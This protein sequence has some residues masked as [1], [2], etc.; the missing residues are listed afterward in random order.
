M[1]AEKREKDKFRNHTMM[2]STTNTLRGC[3]KNEYTN[4]TSVI[5]QVHI[6]LTTDTMQMYYS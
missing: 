1:V 4:V 6:L 5:S 2:F 3:T